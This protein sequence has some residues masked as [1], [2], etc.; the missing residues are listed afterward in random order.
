VL[1]R[2]TNSQYNNTVRDLLGDQTQPAD[3]FPV[4]DFVRGFKNQYDSQNRSPLLEEAP[5][6]TEKLAQNA[7]RNGHSII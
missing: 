6:A 7:F 3:Q 2:L 1:R 5:S 4:E